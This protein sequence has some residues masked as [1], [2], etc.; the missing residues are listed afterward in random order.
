VRKNDNEDDIDGA[1]EE[2]KKQQ[3]GINVSY[4][5]GSQKSTLHSQNSCE[6]YWRWDESWKS[7]SD[8]FLESLELDCAGYSDQSLK[9]A[10]DKLRSKNSKIR[11]SAYSNSLYYGGGLLEFTSLSITAL[12]PFQKI[13]R[14][15][16]QYKM[17]I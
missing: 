9:R 16:S 17:K 7:N 6:S 13:S 12:H 2:F 15:I 3:Q 14:I 8:K 10:A 4:Y 11:Q 1:V 5:S